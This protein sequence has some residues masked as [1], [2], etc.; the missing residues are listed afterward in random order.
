MSKF[1][2]NCGALLDD[3]AVM[4]SNCGINIGEDSSDSKKHKR[5]KSKRFKTLLICIIIIILGTL[6]CVGYCVADYYIDMSAVNI[7]VAKYIDGYYLCDIKYSDV[8]DMVPE[9]LVD[10]FKDSHSKESLNKR[11]NS[12]SLSLDELYGDD[13]LVSY[14]IESFDC[15][16]SEMQ[17]ILIMSN[18]TLF[19]M[20]YGEDIDEEIEEMYN[21]VVEIEIEGDNKESTF[22]NNLIA[23]KY[24][25]NWYLFSVTGYYGAHLSPVAYNI[26]G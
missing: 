7:E 1:C 10:D 13:I 9:P 6:G 25:D 8:V 5:K 22:Y 20:I 4:C 2:G 12:R 15:V 19:N 26:C 3:T 16:S 14:E 24:D 23:V 21:V 18:G 17:D 11:L